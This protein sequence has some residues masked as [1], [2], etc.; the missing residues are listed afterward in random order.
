[1]RRPRCVQTASARALVGPVDAPAS[2]A[3]DTSRARAQVS[4]AGPS[5]A[6]EARWRGWVRR[7]VWGRNLRACF[8]APNVEM[9]RTEEC[10]AKFEGLNRS[11]RSPTSRNRSECRRHPGRRWANRA[12][13]PRIV[14]ECSS[15][16][17][18]SAPWVV[19][20][21]AM[22]GAPLH[23]PRQAPSAMCVLSCEGAKRTNWATHLRD[24][25]HVVGAV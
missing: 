15:S 11:G 14:S 2:R 12:P 19:R 16:N 21:V 18:D 7:A 22:S 5:Q 4:R 9:A 13:E 20:Q 3:S 1:M 8:F 6:A 23:E 25:L 17:S 24:T 10:R